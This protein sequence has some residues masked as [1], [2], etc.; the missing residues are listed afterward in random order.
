MEI[1]N[2]KVTDVPVIHTLISSYAQLDRMLFR[3]HADIY[4]NLQQFKVAL[5]NNTPIACCALQIVWKDLA[6]IKSIAVDKSFAGKGIGTQLVEAHLAAAK[7][8]GL[9]KVFTLTLEPGF[10]E[11]IGFKIIAKDQLPM[12]VWSDCARCSKQ[13]HCDETAMIKKII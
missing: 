1:R 4:E 12:K 2:A 9:E 6:E 7:E 10:F 11:K 3:S 8:M 5:D 13:D